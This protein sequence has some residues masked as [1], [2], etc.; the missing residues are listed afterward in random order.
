MVRSHVKSSSNSS[1]T[2][3]QDAHTPERERV[4]VCVF[5]PLTPL[6]P[7]TPLTLLT[8][9]ALGEGSKRAVHRIVR[10]G[11]DPLATRCPKIP[12]ESM[13]MTMK[14]KS[15]VR[16]ITCY[17]SLRWNTCL[18]TAGRRCSAKRLGYKP[19]GAKPNKDF[20]KASQYL[21]SFSLFMYVPL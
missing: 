14:M 20:C 7:M 10:H 18:M 13:K 4:C 2:P 17:C 8:L 6:T 9:N 3:H 15:R 21:L 1:R 5:S 11:L 19:I 16:E 12:P